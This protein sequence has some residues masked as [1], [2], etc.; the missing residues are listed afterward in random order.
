[1]PGDALYVRDVTHPGGECPLHGTEGDCP[2]TDTGLLT[3]KDLAAMAMRCP[4]CGSPLYD[5]SSC[6]DCGHA[7]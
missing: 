7:P 6:P 3:A 4:R 2:C 1:M 5:G